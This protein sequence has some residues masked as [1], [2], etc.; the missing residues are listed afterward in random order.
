MSDS[1]WPNGLQHARLPCPSPSPRACSNSCPLRWLCHPIISS[2]VAPF[3]SC[4]QSFP[5]S[6]GQSIGA[7]ASVM[8]I[9]KLK[10]SNAKNGLPWWLSGK[11]SA[12]QYRRCK[13]DPWVGKISWR[14]KWQATPVFLP[15]KSPGQK[16]LVGYSPWGCKRVRH[17]LAT[18]QQQQ[19]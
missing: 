18:K 12:C 1:L 17:D 4:P 8:P 7:S 16:S 10:L 6:G 19:W 5:A 13:F 15:R 9:L 3:S 14:R 11:E 2:S